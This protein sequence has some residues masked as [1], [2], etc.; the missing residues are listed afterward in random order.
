VLSG[1]AEPGI[2]AKTGEQ[3]KRKGFK[4]VTVGN[5]S[6][7]SRRTLVLYATAS[8]RAHAKALARS[9]GIKATKPLDPVNA[10]LAPGAQLVVLVGADRER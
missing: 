4:V 10:A 6:G 5:A 7:P 2:A 1:S 8:D 3:L 9:L